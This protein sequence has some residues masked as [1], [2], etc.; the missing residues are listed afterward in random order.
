M[1]IE[2]DKTINV[3]NPLSDG[4][5]QILSFLFVKEEDKTMP[6]TRGESIFFTAIT[7]WMMVYAMTFYNTGLARFIFRC[8]FIKGKS[9]KGTND[10]QNEAEETLHKTLGC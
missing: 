10:I 1:N 3:I 9:P 6:R 7:A 8:I 2:H 5:I 4:L